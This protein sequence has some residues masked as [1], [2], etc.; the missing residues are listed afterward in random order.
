MRA[1]TV[2]WPTSSRGLGLQR[3]VS[4]VNPVRR[5]GHKGRLEQI[6]IERRVESFANDLNT[7]R[8]IVSGRVALVPRSTEIQPSSLRFVPPLCLSKKTVHQKYAFVCLLGLQITRNANNYTKSQASKRSLVHVFSR[9]L[10]KRAQRKV[11]IGTLSESTV[12]RPGKGPRRARSQSVPGRHAATRSRRGSSSSS[13]P[14]ADGFGAGT[15][16]CSPWRPDAVMST[17]GRGRHSVLRIFKG[18]RGRTG[19]H[20]TC[21]ALPAAGPYLRLSRFQGGQ[22]VKQKRELFRG[23][24]RRSDSLTLPSAATSRFRN[25][26]PIPFRSTRAA[27]YQ[28]GF[29]RLLG[30]TNPCASAFT[31]NLSPLRPSKFSFEYLLLPPRSAPAAAPPGLA[32]QVSA[33]FGTVTRLPVH[34]AS[35]VLLTKNGPLGAL[36]SVARLNRAAAP[37]YLFKGSFDSAYAREI[38]PRKKVDPWVIDLGGRRSKSSSIEDLA[39]RKSDCLETSWEASFDPSH[40][41]EILPRKKFDPWVIDFGWTAIPV[42][43][44]GRPT[45]MALKLLGRLPCVIGIILTQHMHVRFCLE[46]KLTHG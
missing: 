5:M 11:Q 3:L 45:R 37:S 38:L 12:R 28:T 27:R 16:G 35:P 14:T 4:L 19:H 31:W 44:T 6:P 29:P 30:S 46:K 43:D 34:P 20:A 23:P 15:P 18:R 13:P 26:N 22:A 41:R 32:P 10:A 21:G 40:A 1:P 8:G 33:Q 42:V 2:R 9:A 36:D 7:R 24:R 17:T 39:A 25:F